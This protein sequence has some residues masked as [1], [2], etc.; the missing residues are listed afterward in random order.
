MC[1]VCKCSAS[2]VDPNEY[3]EGDWEGGHEQLPEP[4]CP[5]VAGRR[6]SGLRRW[7][8]FWN[9]SPQVAPWA[10]TRHWGS[11][12]AASHFS[13]IQHVEQTLELCYMASCCYTLKLHPALYPGYFWC[14]LAFVILSRGL[15]R[16][17]LLTPCP[18]PSCFTCMS[19]PHVLNFIACVC[20]NKQTPAAHASCLPLL[21]SQW[22]PGIVYMVLTRIQINGILYYIRVRTF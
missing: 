13:W 5:G 8:K 14:L 7:I 11:S 15:T 2:T 9:D 19:L 3:S 22:H 6:L 10:C 1:G 17:V 18:T 16:A 4:P 21:S 20:V 12:R